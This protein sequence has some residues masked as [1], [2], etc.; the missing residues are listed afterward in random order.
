MELRRYLGPTGDA[1]WDTVRERHPDVDLVLLPPEKPE[2]AGPA[3]SMS[4]EAVAEIIDLAARAWASVRP[5]LLARGADDAPRTRW[6]ARDG[7]HALVVQQ[8]VVGL[9]VEGADTLTREIGDLLADVGWRVGVRDLGDR[10]ALLATNGLIDVRVDAGPGAVSVSIAT[11][12]LPVSADDWAL[13]R[14][15][16]LS[17][18]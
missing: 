17:W 14:E 15:R 3:G 2:P 1:F 9:G 8:S 13:C 16:V 5:L 4:S 6:R 10:V 11:G 7:R 18:L 12:L